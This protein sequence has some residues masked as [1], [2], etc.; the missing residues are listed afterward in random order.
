MNYIPLLSVEPGWFGR[1][2]GKILNQ[3]RIEYV[4]MWVGS[5]PLAVTIA[6]GEAETRALGIA[7]LTETSCEWYESSWVWQF[8]VA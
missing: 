4:E 1:F 2:S 7:T 8:G 6:A 3:K 5:C